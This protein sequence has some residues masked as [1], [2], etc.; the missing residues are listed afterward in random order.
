MDEMEERNEEL[1][2]DINQLKEQMAQILEMLQSIQVKNVEATPPVARGESSTSLAYPPCFTPTAAQPLTLHLNKSSQQVDPLEVQWPPYGLLPNYAP[3]TIMDPSDKHQ[4]LVNQLPTQMQP[5]Q[6]EVSP[7]NVTS[8]KHQVPYQPQN[9]NFIKQG[10]PYQTFG[11]YQ[12][13]SGIEQVQSSEKLQML[14]ERLKVMEG[15]SYDVGEAVDLCLVPDIEF[16]PKSK[17]PEFDKYKGTSCPKNHITMY[18]RK[19]AAYA[20]NDKLLIHCF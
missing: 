20:H 14:E 8:Y 2:N 4:P 11:G 1:R 7:M 10:N 17:V 16:P 13:T 18:C 12:P 5:T 9:S 15:S 19:M 3:P 6:P